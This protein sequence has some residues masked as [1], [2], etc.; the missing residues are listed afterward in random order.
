MITKKQIE[1]L[2]KYELVVWMRSLSVEVIE[3]LFRSEEGREILINICGIPKELID[4]TLETIQLE[5]KLTEQGFT[6][7]HIMK[8]GEA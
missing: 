4:E 6:D 3:E 2:T 7:A 5:E 8:E 1:K